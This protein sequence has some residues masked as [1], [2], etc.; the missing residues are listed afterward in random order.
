MVK[1][2]IKRQTHIR[3][4]LTWLVIG[5]VSLLIIYPLV[6]TVGASLNPGNSLMS[7]S[8]IP[9]N[10]SLEH[11]AALFNGQV[12]YVTWYWNS[13]KIS[14]FTMVL[15]LIF[16]SFTAYSFSRFR[17]V[18]RKNGLVLFLLLQMI[19]Q[20]SALIAIF[21]LSQMLGLVNSHLALVLIYVGG[22]IPMNTYL[23]KGYIDAIPRDMDESA[24]MDGA[25]HFRIFCEIIMPLSKPIIAVIAL[26]SFTG[27]LGDFILSTTILRTPDQ[28]TLPIGLYN[29][30]SVK[31][32]VSYTTYAAGAVLISVPVA[33]LFLWLQKFFV[34]GLTAG[35]SKG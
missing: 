35:G 25:G 33:L 34:S 21:V 12:D 29:L 17:F 22:M 18:G 26:F 16:V 2:S 15:T 7:S 14:F 27:P 4:G 5:F 9:K 8:I 1:S 11:Y 30:V 3:L 31:M 20:F 28:F 23:M 32:G 13:M 24:R 10:I 19:P 6:W